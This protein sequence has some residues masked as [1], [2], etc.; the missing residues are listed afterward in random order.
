MTSREPLPPGWEAVVDPDSGD[1]FYVNTKEDP[2]TVQWYVLGFF[3]SLCRALTRFRCSAGKILASH[4]RTRRILLRVLLGQLRRPPRAPRTL[5]CHHLPRHRCLRC[6][7]EAATRPNSL[8]IQLLLPFFSP[9]NLNLN[10]RPRP[11]VL[12]LEMCRLLHQ[13]AWNRFL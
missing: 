10:N 2:P 9:N 11:V 7:L 1:T 3:G 8:N 13:H 12:L 6:Q 5:S 4:C